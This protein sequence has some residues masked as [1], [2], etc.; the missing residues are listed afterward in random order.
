[1]REEH[2]ELNRRWWDER[3]PI[4]TASEFYDVEAFRAGAGTLRPFELEEV[5]DV[6][7]KRLVHL[8]CHFGLDTLSW[9]LEPGI[10]AAS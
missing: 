8:Q 5:G 1:M 3:V 10:A 2:R 6:A 9:A 7:E 4:H